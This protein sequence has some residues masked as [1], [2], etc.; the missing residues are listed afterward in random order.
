MSRAPAQAWSGL[1]IALALGT[2]AA[3]AAAWIAVDPDRAPLGSPLV[4]AIGE[5]RSAEVALSAAT[6]DLTAATS[7]T[8]RALA[9]APYDSRARLRLAH[10]DSLDGD[11]SPDGLAALDMSYQL[12]PFDQYVSAWRVRFALNHWGLLSPELR[13][14]VEAEAF[15]FAGTARR[16]EM[17]A[18]LAAVS[19]PTGV[20]PA[21]FWTKRMQREHARRI[22]ARRLD[23]ALPQEQAPKAQSAREIAPK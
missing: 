18:T 13:K 23:S 12:L 14:K 1:F 21:A 15:A 6:P 22:A 19:S 4:L 17:L 8:E 16:R 11:L 10:I 9:Q 7:A 3:A 20:V 5:S 2:V